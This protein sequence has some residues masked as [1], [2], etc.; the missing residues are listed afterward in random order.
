MQHNTSRTLRLL[1]V[2]VAALGLLA[3]CGGDSASGEDNP[4]V[5]YFV[6]QDAPRDEA[7]CVAAELGDFDADEV[8]AAFEGEEAPENEALVEALF[9]AVS[10]CGVE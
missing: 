5:E 6:S 3:A 1:A 4:L 10:T 9:A 7:E 8:I 2:P